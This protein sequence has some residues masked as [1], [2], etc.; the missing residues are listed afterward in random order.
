MLPTPSPRLTM[1]H[2]RNKRTNNPYQQ[3]E[4]R[5]ATNQRSN[6]VRIQIS[7]TMCIFEED[8]ANVKTILAA[9][10]P[11]CCFKSPFAGKP[12]PTSVHC[13]PGPPLSGTRRPAGGGSRWAVGPPTVLPGPTGSSGCPTVAVSTQIRCHCP[14]Q[15]LQLP[16]P[17]TRPSPTPG[18]A[19]RNHGMNPAPSRPASIALSPGRVYEGGPSW[20]ETSP[21]R[22]PRMGRADPHR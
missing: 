14:P 4:Y 11:C 15:P 5:A 8:I 12:L 2:G 22:S 3:C 21:T 16:L 6:Q 17:A 13:P 9:P 19:A 20:H 7:N 1:S 18:S 10:H